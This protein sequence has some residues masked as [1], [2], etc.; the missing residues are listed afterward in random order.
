MSQAQHF[1]QISFFTMRSNYLSCDGQTAPRFNKAFKFL[2]CHCR[3]ASSSTSG[4]RPRLSSTK[5]SQ[6]ALLYWST[7]TEAPS[8]RAPHQTPR[9]PA[10]RQLP[11][12]GRFEWTFRCVFVCHVS[13]HSCHLSTQPHSVIQVPGQHG[14]HKME[15]QSWYRPFSC[16]RGPDSRKRAHRLRY[17]S[18]G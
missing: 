1:A 3:I 12:R 5:A 16:T 18:S 15:M 10:A 8:T 6:V 14:S 7:S 11:N 17:L 2:A 13:K 4:F 9:L